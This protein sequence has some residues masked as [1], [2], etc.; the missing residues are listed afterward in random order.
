MKIQTENNKFLQ[1]FDPG[2]YKNKALL[3][4]GGTGSFGKAFI[5]FMLDNS[6]LSRLVIFSRDENK[7]HEL[8]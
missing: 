8:E 3:V 2:I 7:Q 6:E 1:N 4:T 5:N